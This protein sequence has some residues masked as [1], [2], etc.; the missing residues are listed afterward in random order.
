MCVRKRKVLS[1]KLDSK[2]DIF[3]RASQIIVG[4]TSLRIRRFVINV[5]VIGF[6]SS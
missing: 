3:F 1:L 6:S 2:Q 4:K 5:N